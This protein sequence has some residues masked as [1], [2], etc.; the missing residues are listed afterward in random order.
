[1]GWRWWWKN[2]FGLLQHTG[3]CYGHSPWWFKHWLPWEFWS[4]W[5]LLQCRSAEF[6][7]W[8]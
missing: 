5:Y 1:M 6:E 4:S 7:S 8:Q 2:F 3:R